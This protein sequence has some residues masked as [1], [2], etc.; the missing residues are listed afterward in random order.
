MAVHDAKGG[1][2]LVVSEVSVGFRYGERGGG[3]MSRW[4][5]CCSQV[6]GEW[7]RGVSQ[8]PFLTVKKL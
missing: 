2:D 3:E 4:H 5:V 1:R 8:H 7:G 6:L